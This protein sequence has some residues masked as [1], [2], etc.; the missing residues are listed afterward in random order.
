VAQ[1]SNQSKFG[2]NEAC[3]RAE[4]SQ[5]CCL[6]VGT[7]I[8]GRRVRVIGIRVQINGTRVQIAGIRVQITGI[9][10]QITGTRVQIIGL[11]ALTAD[12][13]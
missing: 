7:P 6:Q 5:A 12:C 1:L 11:A 8:V 10:V 9:R 4:V 3:L 2:V 13:T